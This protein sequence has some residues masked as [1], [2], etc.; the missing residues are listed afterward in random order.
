MSDVRSRFRHALRIA[1][2]VQVAGTRPACALPLGQPER[3]PFRDDLVDR[4]PGDAVLRN[5]LLAVAFRLRVGVIYDLL[6][7][8]VVREVAADVL[9]PLALVA[10]VADRLEL[11]GEL[12]D[13][14]AL[15][16]GVGVAA[17]GEGEKGKKDHGELR[18]ARVVAEEGE[19]VIEGH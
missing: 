12:R 1:L 15:V 17:T 4:A 13:P 10:E 3:V 6:V 2:G 18:E 19:R 7:A 9:R 11:G 8:R 5:A 16:E 14:C